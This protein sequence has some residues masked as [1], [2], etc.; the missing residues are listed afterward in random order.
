MLDHPKEGRIGKLLTGRIE[1]IVA[2]PP[3][4]VIGAEKTQ[5]PAAFIRKD[6]IFP[7]F[8]GP[9]FTSAIKNKRD[10]Q[11]A[12]RRKGIRKL[13]QALVDSSGSDEYQ[14]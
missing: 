14:S 10:G 3:G 7:C 5:R 8:F 4:K 12:G 2:A 11:T 9:G 6:D 1:A 13:Q